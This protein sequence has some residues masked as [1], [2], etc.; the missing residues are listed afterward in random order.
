[1]NGAK[2]T[3]LDQTAMTWLLIVLGLVILPHS[4]N[5]PIWI[6]LLALAMGVWRWLTTQR[7]WPLP[8][9]IIKLLLTLSLVAGVFANYGTLVGRDSG[10]A[11]LVVMVGLKLVELR[12]RRDVLV[13]IF[14]AY[15]LLITHFIFSQTIPMAIYVLA[16][17]WLLLSL[18]MHLT[19]MELRSLRHNLRTSAGLMLLGLP[20]MLALFILFPRIEGPIWGLPDDAFAD[21]TGLGSSM[22]PGDI[23]HLSQSDA[24]A[25]R[26]KFDDKVPA[27]DKRY[28]RGPVLWMTDGRRWEVGSA[29]RPVTWQTS[30]SSAQESALSYTVT[31]EPHNQKWLFALDIPAAANQHGQVSSDLQLV[32]AKP[33]RQRLKYHMTSYLDYNTGPLTD[34]ER[35]LGLFLPQN[36][37]PRTLAFGRSLQINSRSDEEVVQ[38]ALAMFRQQPFIYSLRPPLL[39]N[40]NPS[41]QFLFETR[42]GFCEHYASSFTMLMRAAGIPARVV[43]GYLGAEL[44]PVD[45]Y[46]IVRQRDAHAWAEVWLPKQGWVRI[47]PTAAVA[48]ERV[49]RSIDISLFP[50]G[51]VQFRLPHSD[52]WSRTWQQ[53]SLNIDAINNRWNQLVL[54]YGANQQREFLQNLGL[55][56]EN[57]R[58]LAWVFLVFIGGLFLIITAFILI[59]RHKQVDPVLKN[60]QRF[61]R[62]LA[63]RG[64]LR[65]ESEPATAYA[66]RVKESRPDLAKTINRITALYNHL[67]YADGASQKQF[68]SFKKQITAFKP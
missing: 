10:T 15:F 16:C 32:A 19:S 37:N 68:M 5:L 34:V 33:V 48:P 31:L 44:N 46:Y 36:Q 13:L 4:L 38:K 67:R 8:G 60:Y 42:T 45:D 53:L 50:A 6:S 11:L 61:C 51:A 55:D 7:N 9:N 29:F 56:I 12:Q 27:A 30:R 18:H 3:V 20:L 65:A 43:T 26:V 22:S 66:Q 59:P 58:T 40:D 52:I 39:N 14:L 17:S 63:R 25:F 35:R 64:L 47:D 23:S 24:V 57:W 62:K 21:M 28:W 2:I 49:E 54:G 41:D 1:M